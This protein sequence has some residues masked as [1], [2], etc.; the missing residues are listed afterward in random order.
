MT[1]VYTQSQLIADI[2]TGIR[3]KIGMIS[4]T[5][6]LANNA[7]RDV[8]SRLNTRSTRR[9]SDL[10]P[11]LFPGIYQYA[12]PSD[13]KDYAIIDIPAQAK[14][15]DGSFGLVPTEQFAVNKKE[16]DIAIDDYNGVRTLLINSGATTD[17]SII[18]ELDS[19][20]S[21]GG[22]WTAV[23][24]ATNLAADNDDYI[25]GNGSISFDIGTGATTT[26]GI[27]NSSLDSFSLADFF[28]G[29]SAI[30]VWAR[31]NSITNLTSYTLRIGSSA[32]NYYSKTITARH[33]GNAFQSG[34]N[35]LRFDLTNLT[36]TGSP[37]TTAIRYCSI[38]MNKTSGKISE[39]EYK[40]DWIVAITG[41][42][43]EVAY[44]SKYAWTTSAGVYIENST[45]SSDLLAADT[46]EYDIFVAAGIS[47]AARQVAMDSNTI[48]RM[49]TDYEKM[50]QRY[51]KNN[52]NE[53]GTMTS[54]YYQYG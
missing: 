34:W 7:A 47:N 3:G 24:D 9:H 40:F 53:A 19:L 27:V 11:N 39:T 31:I 28:G 48:A 25:K 26:A 50:A 38:F 46:T 14:R 1:F 29:E 10:T 8:I 23:G 43:H 54:T 36:T 6:D 49:D 45:A 18:A 51:E 30:F 17:Q 22:T 20:T 13:L 21:G 2:N 42:I 15:Q 32:S 52:P 16:G 33:D 4:N 12:C 35:L 37:V 44:Y 41:I 5:T